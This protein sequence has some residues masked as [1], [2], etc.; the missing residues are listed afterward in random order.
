LS[1][2]FKCVSPKDTRGILW[3]NYLL[4]K[5][6]Y[7]GSKLGDQVETVGSTHKVA[8]YA[9]AWRVTSIAIAPLIGISIAVV[10]ISGAAFGEKNF[11]KA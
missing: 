7:I 8:I 4:V 1:L 9:T 10:S 3:D 11:K 2:Y 6:L 5:L